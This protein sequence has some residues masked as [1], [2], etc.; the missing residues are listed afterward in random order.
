MLPESEIARVLAIAAH[1]DDIDFG[2]AGTIAAFTKAGVQVSYLIATPGDAGGFD[3]AVPRA[4]IPGI[5]RAEQRAAAE[6]VGVRDVRF[7]D[8]SD[9]RVEATL[10]LRRDI[11]RVIR[12]MRPDLAIIPTPERNYRNIQPSHPDHRAVGSAALDAI[13][14]DARNPFAYPELL[15]DE[16]LEPWTVRETWLSGGDA[17]DHYVDIT[18]TFDRKVEALRAH[19]SQ[20]AG[21]ADLPG[22]LRGWL[23][24]AAQAAGLPDGHLAESFTAIATG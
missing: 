15:R 24:A 21:M 14:P 8:Y 13:Y 1:P 9:G 17:P 20:T 23:G 10:A 16:R 4:D 18:D 11:A 2:A 12:Q 3:P 5:R 7:L 22:M 6:Q 19:R